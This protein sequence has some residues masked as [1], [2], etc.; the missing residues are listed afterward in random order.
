MTTETTRLRVNITITKEL[1][2]ALQEK[3]SRQRI[4]MRDAIH[5]ALVDWAAKPVITIQWV[6]KAMGNPTTDLTMLKEAA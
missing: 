3:A 4:T 5:Q 2:Q 1:D 6:D